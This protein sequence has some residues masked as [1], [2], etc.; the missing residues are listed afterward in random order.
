MSYAIFDL[1]GTLIDF[2]GISGEALRTV[3]KR[4]GAVREFSTKLHSSILGTPAAYWSKRLVEELEIPHLTPLQLID[5]Y[6]SELFK[7]F[8]R[9]TLMPGAA[10]LL[11]SLRDRNIPVAIA[12][13]SA[14]HSVP[15]KLVNH[16]IISECTTVIVTGD[17]P[18]V[19]NGKPSPDIFQLAA[20]RLG[21]PEIDFSKCIVF[22]DAPSGVLGGIRAGMRVIAIPD[23]R[24]LS[25]ENR[26]E[27][28]DHPNVTVVS[29][30]EHVDVDVIF[31]TPI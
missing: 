16:P 22:E 14:S 27:I 6:H 29:S 20:K 4:G 1:D 2:E 15:K 21:C 26:G 12:T 24:Y 10:N 19:R 3:T 31:S 18:L 23:N 13:S 8:P 25:R 30:L 17:D 28:F 11:R 9:L 7:L 5:E